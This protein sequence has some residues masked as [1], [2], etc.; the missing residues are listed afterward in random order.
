MGLVLY[1]LILLSEMCGNSRHMKLV[2]TKV[3]LCEDFLV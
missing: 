3:D 2:H 1:M